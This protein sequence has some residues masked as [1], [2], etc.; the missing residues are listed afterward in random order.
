MLKN[1]KILLGV[2]GGIAAYKSPSICS[3]LRKKGFEVKV[4]M[5][6]NAKEFIT[7]LSLQTMSNNTVHS[8][9]FNQL[10]NTDV[11]HISLAKWADII[12]IAPATANIIGKFANGI[13]DDLL[14]TV[15][16]A[17]RCR[18]LI[19]PAMNT[20]MLNSPANINNMEILKNRGI[21]I[22]DTEKDLLACNDY[23]SGKMLSPEKIVDAIDDNLTEKDLAGKKF[24]ITAGPTIE[25]LDPVRF[26]TNHSSGKMGYALAANA[27]KRGAEVTLITGPTN[28][29]PPKVHRLVKINTTQDMFGAVG[30]YFDDCHVLIKAAAPADYKPKYYSK[31]KIKKNSSNDLDVIELEKNP[32][33]AKY[34]GKNKVGQIIVGFAAES[35][36]IYKYA[37]EKL[38]S[39]NLDMIVV[40]NI[41][42]AGAGFGT[43]T[44]IAS[45]IDK[46][47]ETE[48]FEIMS[49]S[50]LANIIL[51]KV[52]NLF[53]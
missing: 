26:L 52:K 30:K 28:I 51:N 19:A 17:S 42:K 2:S 18:V 41:V 13:C 35:T 16:M 1:K 9:M 22:L 10:L 12:V 20:E 37:K 14:T 15:F 21:V 44:N 46:N 32:D 34:Y 11:E 29:E 38:V 45:I 53:S 50:E 8:K 43:D 36:N 25:P 6:E 23:G 47:G 33:I 7:P 39:K 4:M 5:T 31:D 49:K 40:N 24:L 48:D 27:Q 3:L